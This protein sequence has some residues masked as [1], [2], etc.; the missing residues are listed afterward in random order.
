MPAAAP[1]PRPATPPVV[2]ADRLR[3]FSTV[4]VITVHAAA[5]IAQT[6]MNY[7]SS[8]WWASAWW[9]ALGR[10]AVPLFIML[11]G[12]LLLSKDYPLGAFMKKRFVRVFVPSLFWMLV[13]MWYDYHAHPRPFTLLIGLRSL[14]QG[15]VYFHLWFIYLILALYLLYPLFRPWIKQATD[16]QFWFYFTLFFIGA[17]GYKAMDRFFGFHP[18]LFLDLFTNHVGTFIMGYY[19]G[20]KPFAGEPAVG[21]LQPWRYTARQMLPVAWTLIVWGTVATAVGAHWAGTTFGPAYN[22]YFFDY[23]TP[24]VGIATIGWFLLAR[25]AWNKPA[26]TQFEIEFAAASFGIYFGHVIV[27]DWWAESGYWHSKLHPARCIPVVI[28]LVSLMSFVVISLLR[29]SSFGRRV[30]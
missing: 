1:A 25:I 7:N 2:W 14:V 28:G 17:W 22:P 24:N 20:V 12:Y 15:P 21:P 27:M 19:F 4:L 13:Y 6:D 30:T 26:L 3:N 11:S 18:G 9:N 10:P 5:S 16:K 8:E 23:L 29:V